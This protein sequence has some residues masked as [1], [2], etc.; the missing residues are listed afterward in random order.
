MN[1]NLLS[2][3]NEFISWGVLEVDLSSESNH[4]T[5]LGEVEVDIKNAGYVVSNVYQDKQNHRL[6]HIHIKREETKK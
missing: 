5:I 1:N 3:L 4:E 2:K 6:Y